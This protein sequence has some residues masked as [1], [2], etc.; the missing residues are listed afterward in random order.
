MNRGA[1]ETI[2]GAVVLL[3]AVGFVVFGA[4]T[5]DIQGSESRWAGARQ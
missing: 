3:V 4:R 5:V 2:L 1:L